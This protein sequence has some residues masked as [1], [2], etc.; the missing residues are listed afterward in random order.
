[1]TELKAPFPYFGGKSTVAE[2]VWQRFGVVDN[3]VEPFFGS[4][5]VLLGA[6][7]IPRYETVNDMDAFVAN[8]WRAMQAEPDTLAAGVDWPVNEADLDARHK[9]LCEGNRKAEFSRR[10]KAEPEYY[11]PRIAA[12]WCWGLCA[13]IGGGWCSGEWWGRGDE[14]TTGTGIN[15]ANEERGGKRPHLGDRGHGVHRKRPHLSC[16]GM[17]VHRQLPDAGAHPCSEWFTALADRLR[18]VRV[19]CG[20]WSRVCTHTPTEHLGLT[21]VFLDPPY[22]AEAGRDMHIYKE[23][24][25]TV[26][27][28]VREWAIE[29]GTS[30]MMRIALCGYEGEHAMPADWE[31]VPWKASGGYGSQAAGTGRA[32]SH[33]ER[34][35]FSPH[36]VKL[37]T[38]APTLFDEVTT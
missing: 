6:P 33:R 2:L 5:A 3:Y 4:G 31:C 35:W 11:D 1:M 20:D 32:N 7:Y 27:H 19:C 25:G 34:I 30:P 28:A 17:G 37:E 15:V 16:R 36:C 22:S 14:R 24:S 10:M 12:W 13:W 23:E 29:R 26:A 21:A 8:F 18:R 9:W 38:D